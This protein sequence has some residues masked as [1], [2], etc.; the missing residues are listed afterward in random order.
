MLAAVRCVRLCVCAWFGA[1]YE[2]HRQQPLA[3]LS[4]DVCLC[5]AIFIAAVTVLSMRVGVGVFRDASHK[6]P[7]ATT[8]LLAVRS[9]CLRCR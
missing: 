6:A 7:A 2:H 9:A 4:V 5:C 8:V 3:V 1:P